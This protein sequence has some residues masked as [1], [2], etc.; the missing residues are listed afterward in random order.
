MTSE[1]RLDLVCLGRASVD[2][3]GEQVGGRLEDM[4]S[5]AKYVG[6]SPTN[7][8]IGTARLGLKSALI[9]RVGDEHMGRFIRET[10]V[11]EGVDV[12][13]V[14]T[15]PER[16]TA[17]VILGI[18][19]QRTFPL[20]FYRENCA[21][22]AIA[23]EDIE[24][25]FIA[26]A[27]ALL[28]SGT[29]FS[30]PGVDRA[31]R[32]AIRHARAAGTRVA[33]D[34]DYRPVLW[35][36]A[37]HGLGEERY[38]A[39]E[40]VSRHLQSIV[41][42]C[43]LVVGTEEEIHIAGGSADTVAA[44]RRLRRLTRAALVVKRGAMGCAVFPGPIPDSVEDGISGPGF[45]VEVFN[46]L[47]AGDAFMAGFLRGWLRGEP[48]ETCC[49]YANACGAFV[50][51]RHGC[52]PA[53]PTWAEVEAFLARGSARR[54]LREDAELEHLH[55]ATT[56]RRDRPDM[57]VLAFDHRQQFEELAAHHGA[58]SGAIA[59]FKGLCWAAVREA[60]P[61]LAGAGILCDDR[62][63]REVLDAASGS[64]I[65]IG[66][67][68]ER[69]GSRPL[70]FEGG[71]DV[72]LTLRS[73]PVEHCVKCLVQYDAADVPA[74]RE[75]Q[76]ERL[77]AL[78]ESCRATGHEL[79][80]EVIAPDDRGSDR[81]GLAASLEAIYGL[82]VRPDWWKLPPGDGASWRRIAGVMRR[83]DPYCRGVLLLGQNAGEDELMG[84]I[85]EAARAPVCRGFA[86][87][88]SIFARP[89]EAWF[90]GSLDD[91][92]AVAAM[93][94]AYG[95]AIACWRGARAAA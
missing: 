40:R 75:R 8:A 83:R 4:A 19:D 41:P 79:M 53:T 7:V 10:L 66:R 21:D 80:I 63:G 24:P 9:T 93:A 49:R 82:G 20:V 13:H 92:G 95:R 57:L 90:A 34:I 16:L 12:S 37:G 43:D 52:A 5:F 78:F 84:A 62:Y 14:R 27:E 47:G 51:S 60:A 54:R 67:P 59:R 36:L 89:A 39:S 94:G 88:R 28:V 11:A 55:W 38:V 18:R 76:D 33:L 31:S 17:L 68:I 50:V 86:V 29:H 30:A 1:R 2:L 42:D 15:D 70:A 45:P 26:G 23:A 44:L 65:W 73:W 61:G 72:G 35:G 91:A 3:Y 48:Y 32:T 56:R 87:G 25:E 69:P 22:M 6:G 77:V 58:P 64:G 81:P 85:A 71:A 46:V 74:I